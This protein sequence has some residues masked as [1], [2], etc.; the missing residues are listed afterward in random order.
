MKN[1]DL[2]VTEDE[3][4]QMKKDNDEQIASLQSEINNMQQG[5][6]LLEKSGSSYAKAIHGENDKNKIP[7]QNLDL[8]R[9]HRGEFKQTWQM[10]KPAK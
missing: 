9:K 10:K 7:T 4:A 2:P 5:M 1:P 3:K 6:M 8:L